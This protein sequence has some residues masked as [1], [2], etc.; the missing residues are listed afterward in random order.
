MIQNDELYNNTKDLR[1]EQ[2]LSYIPDEFK[3][4]CHVGIIDNMINIF[5]LFK[6]PYAEKINEFFIND[7]IEN[8]KNNIYF[9]LFSYVDRIRSY[10]DTNIMS[11]YVF[12]CEKQIN[13]FEMFSYEDKDDYRNKIMSLY[14]YFF[15]SKYELLI[16]IN[17]VYISQSTKY[18]LYAVYQK[19][20]NDCLLYTYSLNLSDEEKQELNKQE[21]INECLNL[22]TPKEQ[23]I[24]EALVLNYEQTARQLAEK[25]T[26]SERT[27][28]KQ[29][30]SLCSKL[31][32]KTGIGNLRNFIKKEILGII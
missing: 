20:L 1:K 6:L 9:S 21:K 30:D 15:M 4:V 25:F 16:S 18:Y 29:I 17:G 26:N 22:L 2:I 19:I 8:T 14:D 11:T 7:L 12:D 3:R 23:K 13:M 24:F 28:E 32:G 27:I 31:A 10:F 5:A